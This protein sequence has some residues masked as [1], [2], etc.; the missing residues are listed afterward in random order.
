[1]KRLNTKFKLFA[2]RYCEATGI[3][4]VQ[5][6]WYR[7]GEPIILTSLPPEDQM[8]YKIKDNILVIESLNPSRDN[9]MYQC[10]ASNQLGSTFSTAQ[11]KIM[12][13]KPVFKKKMDKDMFASTGNNYTLSCDPEAVVRI[14]L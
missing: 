12:S 13:L 1:M 11:L 6:S 14:F 3:P 9:A 10:K 4:S 5:Y 2:Y 7:N 8:R